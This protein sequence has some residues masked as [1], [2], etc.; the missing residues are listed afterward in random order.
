ML[1]IC[2]LF[3]PSS[4]PR[5]I[6]AALSSEADTIIFDLE[7]AVHI[8]EKDSA[9]IVLSYA[10]PL[11]AD[12]NTCVR[13]N[14]DGG[15]YEEDLELFRSGLIKN[16]IIPKAMPEHTKKVS[17]ILDQMN[18][19]TD[20]AVLIET[21]ES[22]EA[23]REIIASSKRISSIL[24]G[25]EDYSLELGTERTP[26]G[27][28]ILYPRIKIANMAKAYELESLD[29]PYADVQNI[30]GLIK[31]CE[32]A[33]G[34]GFTGKLAINP[35]QTGE[36]QRIFRPSDKEVRWAKRVI[37]AAALPDNAGKGAFSLDGNMIDLPI[38]KKAQKILMRA[39]GDRQ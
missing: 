8:S 16:V 9:R 33:K 29:T 32:Y 30:P 4:S 15:C 13:I 18:A 10:L 3:V 35:L 37:E 25:G 22:L 14:A 39:G 27:D 23:L 19:D 38:I 26:G 21:P 1:G 31:D 24:M 2:A 7:D 20:I 5:M 36:I 34:L 6:N 12:R 17:C 28:E 11:F